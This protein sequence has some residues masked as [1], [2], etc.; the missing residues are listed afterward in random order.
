MTNI[1]IDM[2]GEIS[3]KYIRENTYKSFNE[4]R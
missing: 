3:V 1:F 2:K 4:K